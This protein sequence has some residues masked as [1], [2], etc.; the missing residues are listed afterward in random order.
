MAFFEP[1]RAE[2]WGLILE[3]NGTYAITSLL[4]LHG[5]LV[6]YPCYNVKKVCNFANTLMEHYGFYTEDGGKTIYIPPYLSPD[7]I[8]ITVRVIIEPLPTHDGTITYFHHDHHVNKY[9]KCEV[10]FGGPRQPSA[11][12][13][14][15]RRLQRRLSDEWCYYWEDVYYT[16]Y[17]I[18]SDTDQSDDDISPG[19]MSESEYL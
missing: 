7:D 15:L 3:G 5:L 1:E 12:D 19:Y 6:N 18:E 14:G 13:E 10:R 9:W 8:K 11:M 17:S 16:E 2:S 4:R